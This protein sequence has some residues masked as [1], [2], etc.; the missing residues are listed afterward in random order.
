[1]RSGAY[2]VSHLTMD[3]CPR[4]FDELKALRLARASVG[5]SGAPVESYSS[6]EEED[7]GVGGA[8]AEAANVFS[9]A[10]AVCPSSTLVPMANPAGMAAPPAD[11]SRPSDWHAVEGFPRECPWCGQRVWGGR[12]GLEQHQRTSGRC[13]WYRQQSERQGVELGEEHPCGPPGKRSD[14]PPAACGP[15]VVESSPS[16][17]P[18]RGEDKKV[19]R[20]K[21]MGKDKRKNEKKPRASPTPPAKRRREHREPPPGGGAGASKGLRLERVDDTTFIL[22]ME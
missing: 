21:K 5:M 22:R 12:S 4:P 2:G 14:A 7:S 13:Q 6:S 20:E 1:M 9:K 10:A 16:P 3:T 17:P 18:R 15:E 8:V 11:A 19:K